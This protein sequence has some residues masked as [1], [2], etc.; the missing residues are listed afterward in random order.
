MRVNDPD[1]MLM[2]R[3][4]GGDDAAFDEILKKYQ[5]P[6]INFIYHFV[7]NRAEAEEL[8]QDVFLRVYAARAKYQP[9]AKFAT[10][11]YKIATNLC[12]KKLNQ[13]RIS[14]RMKI[15]IDGEHVPELKDLR[16]TIQEVME[17]EEKEAIIAKAINGLPRNEKAAILLRKR[18]SLSYKEIADV[19]GCT[20]GAVKTY[21]HRAKL[22]LRERLS[23]YLEG[24]VK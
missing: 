9:E 3:V 13:D 19:I 11:I 17:T 14:M 21:I 4:K 16:P 2:L 20:E 10:W 24:R 7:N 15:S 18:Q 1:A 22:R 5:K 8:A 12:L 6:L 23:P